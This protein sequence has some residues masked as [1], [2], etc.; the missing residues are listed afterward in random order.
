MYET[1]IQIYFDIKSVVDKFKNRFRAARITGLKFREIDGSKADD[2]MFQFDDYSTAK[3]NCTKMRVLPMHDLMDILM[4][5]EFGIPLPGGPEGYVCEGGYFEPEIA[6]EQRLP[7]E[8][9][10]TWKSSNYNW[11]SF[12]KLKETHNYLRKK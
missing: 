1:A 2:V 6:I 8:L 5:R 10:E 3:E 7:V 4:A 11:E 12:F 9:K